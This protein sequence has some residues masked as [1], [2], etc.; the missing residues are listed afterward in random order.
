MRTA[1]DTLGLIQLA[2]TTGLQGEELMKLSFDIYAE[3]ESGAS[4][5]LPAGARLESTTQ[6]CTAQLA[7]GVRIRLSSAA[8][9][10][11]FDV[12]RESIAFEAQFP[13]AATGLYWI[14]DPSFTYMAP[15]NRPDGL[16]VRRKTGVGFPLGSLPGQQPPTGETFETL[17]SRGTLFVGVEVLNTRFSPPTYSRCLQAPQSGDCPQVNRDFRRWVASVLGIH[18]STFPLT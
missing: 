3:P 8:V 17:M 7:P 10:N 6:G 16:I 14:P 9:G 4:V 15:I 12:Q 5:A 2:G 13:L 18:L 11:P 1:D